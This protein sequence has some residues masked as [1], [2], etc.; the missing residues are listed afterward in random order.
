MRIKV[1]AKTFR[2][3]GKSNIIVTR[4]QYPLVL[5]HSVTIQKSQGQT[6]D[7]VCI[8]FDRTSRSGKE[9]APTNYGQRYTALSRGKE[10]SKKVSII[11]DQETN[12]TFS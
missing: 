3:K 9:I 10:S 11:T 2:L 7:Y 12:K 8:Y 6:D 5:A 1:V 4:K